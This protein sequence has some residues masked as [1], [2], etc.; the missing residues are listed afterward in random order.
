[1]EKVII[2]DWGGVVVNH[3]NDR[4]QTMEATIRLIRRFNK[5]ISE[6]DI[7]EKWTYRNS[8]GVHAGKLN[9][10]KDIRDWID[11]LERIMEIDVPFEVFKEAY[12]E[13][14]EKV[15]HYEEVVE[16]IHSLKDKCKIAILSNLNAFDRKRINA[17]MNFEKFDYVFL[18]FEIGMKKP[19]KQIY[20][21]VLDKLKVS[22][23]D[24]LF[25]DDKLVNIE[26][27]QKC[28]WKT[29]NAFGYELEKIKEEVDKFLK[30]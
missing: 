28:G 13:E 10:E 25:V 5:N 8:S 21:Y 17:H 30:D 14:F 24:I 4:K 9:D 27:A 12:E 1:M 19:D 7:L 15:E 29:C 3:E 20:E 16:Y 23:E 26:A 6:K 18:S 2:F 22:P 11:R